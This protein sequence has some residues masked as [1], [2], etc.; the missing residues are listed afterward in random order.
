[1][2]E[3]WRVLSRYGHGLAAPKFLMEAILHIVLWCDHV[4]LYVDVSQKIVGRNKAF[5][6]EEL[7][8]S[9]IYSM[10]RLFSCCLKIVINVPH[11]KPHLGMLELR[12]CYTKYPVAG[13]SPAININI[14]QLQDRYGGQTAG[15]SNLSILAATPLPWDPW[16]CP[17]TRGVAMSSWTWHG[18]A[19]SSFPDEFGRTW[20]GHAGP[21]FPEVTI[22]TCG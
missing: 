1:M 5:K 13:Y 20:H 6:Q 18:Q 15:R 16:C 21:S 22:N 7:L 8:E 19:G 4:N 2:A 10:W 14:Y 9:R 12:W 17:L 3:K 11:L